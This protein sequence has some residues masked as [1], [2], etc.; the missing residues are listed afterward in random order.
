MVME[1]VKTRIKKNRLWKYIESFDFCPRNWECLDRCL[2]P[3]FIRPATD[4]IIRRAFYDT[5]FM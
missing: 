3:I 2:Q 4:S 1:V 5:I